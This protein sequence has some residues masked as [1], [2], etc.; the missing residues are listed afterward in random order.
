[1]NNVKY[2]SFNIDKQEKKRFTEVIS[3]PE[4]AHFYYEEWSSWR[5]ILKK[6]KVKTSFI[7]GRRPP[8]IAAFKLATAISKNLIIL[9]HA[10]NPRREKVPLSYFIANFKKVILWLTSMLVIKLRL[11]LSTNNNE[12][13]C[14]VRI[15]YFTESYAS[16][17]KNTIGED[18]N[19][20]YIKCTLPDVTQFGTIAKI[21]IN[22][23]EIDCFYVDEPLTTTL[24]ISYQQEIKIL[25][26]LIHE[27]NTKNI[28]VKLHP[29]SDKSKFNTLTEFTLTEQV[30]KNCKILAGYNSAL[31]DYNF[32]NI[33]LIKLQK[34]STW[35]V[36]EPNVKTLQNQSN[37]E[38]DVLSNIGPT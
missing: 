32:N 33:H 3:P 36:S 20:T 35:K 25:K 26:D 9:Q 15:F 22:H 31:M 7:W 38:A 21:K 19:I 1:M 2:L 17:W 13:K 24:G 37:Y 16:E 23:D 27:A 4:T 6:L 18:S 34:D 29:R 30:Y 5:I 11:S 8:D 28:F 14:N 12:Q 10:K